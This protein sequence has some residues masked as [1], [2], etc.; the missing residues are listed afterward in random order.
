MLPD[1]LCS[2]A[3]TVI[4]LACI[5]LEPR[6]AACGV[7]WHV[8]AVRPS[9]RYVCRLNPAPEVNR[10]SSRGGWV[11][12]SADTP[13]LELAGKV[14]CTGGARPIIATDRVVGCSR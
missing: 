10:V 3:S 4:L 1:L 14:Y 6:Q 7:G 11:D 8:E 9:G 12:A 13:D 5:A 2:L